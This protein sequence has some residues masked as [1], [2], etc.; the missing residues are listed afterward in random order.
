LHVAGTAVDAANTFP[1]AED[2]MAAD[3]ETLVDDSV[4]VGVNEEL[5]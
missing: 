5:T 2:E 4:D 3:D 1:A